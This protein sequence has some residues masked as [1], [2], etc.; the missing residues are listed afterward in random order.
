[1]RICDLEIWS[2]NWRIVITISISY[3]LLFDFKE[4][5][6]GFRSLGCWKDSFDRAVPGFQGNLIVN[7]SYILGCYERAKS[8]GFDIF[9]VQFGGECYTSL[10]ASKSY[11]KY[12]PSSDCVSGT[13]G[14]LANDV[15]LRG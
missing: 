9:A 1:M 4:H 6:K 7:G 10:G 13:G 2:Y 8:L 11:N 5:D 14:P 15:Y 3:Y 12:G